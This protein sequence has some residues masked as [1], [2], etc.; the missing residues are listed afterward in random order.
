MESDSTVI[1]TSPLQ[2]NDSMPPTPNSVE[3]SSA[4]SPAVTY[5]SKQIKKEVTVL[6]NNQPIMSSQSNRRRHYSSASSSA[7]ED[8][9]ID[10]VNESANKKA[11]TRHLNK[12]LNSNHAYPAESDQQKVKPETVATNN[13]KGS[14]LNNSLNGSIESKASKHIKANGHATAATILHSPNSNSSSNSQFDT[15]AITS[16]KQES[17]ASLIANLDAEQASRKFKSFLIEDI[18]SQQKKRQQEQ[19]QLLLAQQQ[20]QLLLQQFNSNKLLQQ[21]SSAALPSLS[22]SNQSTNQ[23]SP[24]SSVH[25]LV[26]NSENSL[27]DSMSAAALAAY[28][29]NSIIRPWD[30]ANGLI[31]NS[32]VAATLSQLTAA[33]QCSSSL[34]GQSAAAAN[35]SLPISPSSHSLALTLGTNVQTNSSPSTQQPLNGSLLHSSTQLA[36]AALAAAHSPNK[37]NVQQLG[38]F[39]SL[40]NYPH[41]LPGNFASSLSHLSPHHQF[42]AGLNGGAAAASLFPGLAAANNLTNNAAFTAALKADPSFRLHSLAHPFAGTSTLPAAAQ[43]TSSSA[44]DANLMQQLINSSA[45]NNLSNGQSTN[46]ASSYAN[47]SSSASKPPSKQPINENGKRLN[48]EDLDDE[49]DENDA[50]MDDDCDEKCSISSSTSG[51]SKSKPQTNGDGSS[52]LSALYELANK[53]FEMTRNEKSGK[54]W[55]SISMNFDEFR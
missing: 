32:A 49:C 9:A 42:L 46:K 54:F 18:L 27:N 44:T 6:T 12:R 1:T 26:N 19:F 13:Q 55:K 36:A 8:V 11:T 37:L 24:N 4:S 48:V 17:A 2:S 50:I 14:P 53:N 40:A 31:P 16:L 43:Q 21:H 25:S 39:G 15:S 41:L 38:R 7:D 34:N 29:L 35:S 33:Q 52:P 23:S 22:P 3:N 10:V 51:P 30:L 5:P 20:Q 45:A 47:S 28:S